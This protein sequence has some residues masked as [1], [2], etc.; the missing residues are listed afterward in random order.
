MEFSYISSTS[1]VMKDLEDRIA[2]LAVVAKEGGVKGPLAEA[3]AEDSPHIQFWR[4]GYN[5]AIQDVLKIVRD[6]YQD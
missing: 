3:R 1:A 2:E 6:Y 4:L 5:A